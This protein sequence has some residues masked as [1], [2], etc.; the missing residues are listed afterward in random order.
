MR[1]SAPRER[2]MSRFPVLVTAVTSAPK[3]LAICTAN[4][5]TPPPAPLTST[6]CPGLI[7]PW[8][9]R[10]CSAVN[11]AM[12]TAA[13]SSKERFVG[14]RLILFS[15]ASV[16]IAGPS[17][18]FRENLLCGVEHLAN[19]DRVSFHHIF[20]LFLRRLGQ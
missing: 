15:F 12:G 14:F 7:C 5:P 8:F 11:P 16:I 19:V 9:R 18:I 1:W 6:F 20:H 4:V 2:T 10:A 17:I 13:A 3:D